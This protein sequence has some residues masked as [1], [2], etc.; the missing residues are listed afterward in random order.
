MPNTFVK[1]MIQETTR[2]Q[3][4]QLLHKLEFLGFMQ[5]FVFT[6]VKP[7]QSLFKVLPSHKVAKVKRLQS[8][9]HKVAMIG[10]GVN[11]SPALAQADIGVA[12]GKAFF[13]E[14]TYFYFSN[15]NLIFQ[16]KYIVVKGNVCV[17]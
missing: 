1:R 17:A 16:S 15:P 4:R 7:N 12:I 14:T 3:P 8:E 13:F 2:K 10:D 5:R 9:G 11:D 6:D